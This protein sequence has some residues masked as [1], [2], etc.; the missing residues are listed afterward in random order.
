[1]AKKKPAKKTELERLEDI[2]RK[3]N[4]KVREA[5]KLETEKRSLG[6]LRDG[7]KEMQEAYNEDLKRQTE[8]DTNDKAHVFG[9][10]AFTHRDGSLKWVRTEAIYAIEVEAPSVDA[11]VKA[12]TWL[13]TVDGQV[14]VSESA[15]EVFNELMNVRFAWRAEMVREQHGELMRREDRVTHAKE[16]KRAKELKA[17]AK[18]G[19][20]FQAA[21]DA[22]SDLVGGGEVSAEEMAKP[23]LT[24]EKAQEML[25]QFELSCKAQDVNWSWFDLAVILMMNDGDL[26][27]AF[28]TLKATSPSTGDEAPEDE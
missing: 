15:D 26:R 20:D 4:N 2:A 21:S 27:R 25:Q 10:G 22:V 24:P 7:V 1:M 28:R 14:D 16:K 3:A 5:R 19:P 9:Y 8:Y 18:K 6:G 12:N 13:K 11:G 17:K 23:A